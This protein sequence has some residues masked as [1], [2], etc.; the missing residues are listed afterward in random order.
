[1]SREP[2]RGSPLGLGELGIGQ[3][4]EVVRPAALVRPLG[5]VSLD[6]PAGHDVLRLAQDPERTLERSGDVQGRGHVRGM[7][8][9]GS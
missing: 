1:V 3:P 7:A 8:R 4:E 2:T 5:R 9:S 6:G